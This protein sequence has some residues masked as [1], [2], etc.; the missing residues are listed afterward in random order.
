VARLEVAPFQNRVRVPS[1]EQ[2]IPPVSLRSRIGMTRSV[3]GTTGQDP[4]PAACERWIFLPWERGKDGAPAADPL[5]A[6]ADSSCLAALARRNDNGCGD[7]YFCGGCLR[8]LSCL[9]YWLTWPELG[10]II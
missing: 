4:H 7:S 6:Y 1:G 3:L 8:E 5:L 2:Q 10:V 9:G